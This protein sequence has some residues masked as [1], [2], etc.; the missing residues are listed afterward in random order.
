MKNII[1]SFMILMSVNCFSQ[2]REGLIG[3]SKRNVTKYVEPKPIVFD[4]PGT[5]TRKSYIDP[6]NINKKLIEDLYWKNVILKER[7][8]IRQ[9]LLVTQV[10]LSRHNIIVII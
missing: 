2:T 5:E 8:I 7:K 1:V 3:V 10:V 9:I 4:K 6:Q